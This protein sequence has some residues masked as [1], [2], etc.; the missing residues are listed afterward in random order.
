MSSR[1]HTQTC[2][3]ESIYQSN[4]LFMSSRVH[5]EYI[6]S[7]WDNSL[8][9][10]SPRVN[11]RYRNSGGILMHSILQWSIQLTIIVEHSVLNTLPKRSSRLCL[12]ALT[13]MLPTVHLFGWY[14][15]LYSIEFSIYLLQNTSIQSSQCTPWLYVSNWKRIGWYLAD[16]YALL[17]ERANVF[18]PKPNHSQI[19]KV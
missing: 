13:E 12:P 14:Y 6:R 10:V 19:H 9:R 15:G 2:E 3:C 7:V 11:A 5:L 4:N 8:Y 18:R 16:V 17:F 1:R